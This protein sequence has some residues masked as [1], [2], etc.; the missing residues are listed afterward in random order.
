MFFIASK[1]IWPLLSPLNFLFLLF[2]AGVLLMPLFRRAGKVVVGAAVILFLIFG[3]MPVGPELMAGIENQYSRPAQAPEKVDGIIVLGG[4]LES[5]LIVARDTLVVNNAAERILEGL[6][7]ARLYPDAKLVFSGGEG[8][9][10]SIN[11]PESV[12]IRDFIS[13]YGGVDAAR[14]LYEE[15]SRNTYENAVF[16]RALIKPGPGQHWILVTSAFHMPRAVRVFESAGWSGIV[17]WPVD[18]RTSGTVSA[19][20]DKLNVAGNFMMLDMALHEYVGMLS[21][22]LSGKTGE[23]PGK[24]AASS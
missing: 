9:L 19:F 24:P 3:L 8:Q 22:R 4:A 21:Y 14:P 20:P 16:T 12:D 5:E 1:L 23:K 18:Y 10:H 15:K 6:R 7:L 2:L 11:H 17:P 13:T